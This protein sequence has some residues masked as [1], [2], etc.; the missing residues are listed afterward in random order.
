MPTPPSLPDSTRS[1]YRNGHGSPGKNGHS[2]PES[3]IPSQPERSNGLTSFLAPF[4]GA[5][6]AVFVLALVAV[7]IH[8]G[9]QWL[10]SSSG[11]TQNS[12]ASAAPKAAPVAKIADPLDTISTWRLGDQPATKL[13]GDGNADIAL[14]TRWF[15]LPKSGE[16]ENYFKAQGLQVTKVVPLHYED[17]KESRTITYQVFAQVPAQLLKLPKNSWAPADP[18]L[19]PFAHGVILNEGLPAGV[20]WNTENPVVEAEA[21]T[22]LN[23]ACK[24]RWDKNFNTVTT[25]RL[26][27]TDG[28]FTQ[29]QITSIQAQTDSTVS[30]LKAQVA[31][32]DTQ[33]Q[34]DVQ[35]RLV[36][37]A[38]NPPKPELMSHAWGGDGSG[39][40]TKSAERIGGGTLAG[41]A[42]GA[43]FGA[44]AGD[45][46]M[47]AGIGA[48]VGLLGG[49][50]YDGVSK[51]N[52]R[53]RYEAH[54]DAVNSERMDEW[55]SQ[56]KALDQQR[57]QIKQD[58]ETEKQQML[59]GLADQIAKANG[60][61]DELP[62]PADTTGT[63]TAVSDALPGQPITVGE[64]TPSHVFPVPPGADQPSGPITISNSDAAA[65]PMVPFTA[66]I[67]DS[68][69]PANQQA[70]GNVEVQYTNGQNAKWT[71]DGRSTYAR[72]SGDGEVGWVQYVGQDDKY[73]REKD[74]LNIYTRDGQM[75][76]FAG[77][78]IY[79]QNWSFVNHGAS[80]AIRSMNHH[81]PDYFI[82][83]DI[84][85][86]KTLD[87]I[88]TPKDA[89]DLPAWAVRV[90]PYTTK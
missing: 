35:G 17:D 22:Q 88:D 57:N 2:S 67:V 90:T 60:R 21:G 47:G 81:G 34:N 12:S 62:A 33:V 19:R 77:N 73:G 30:A 70:L 48:G 15:Y 32:I 26:P 86:G 50:I 11:T 25:D 29:E 36:Q 69:Y 65:Q 31:Q 79:I 16:V 40:P 9:L 37:V 82:K 64:V 74:V 59:T 46:G 42:G 5:F 41:A 85:T 61:M 87:E 55:H 10:H 45:A 54:V 83:Y 80:V 56:V 84:A 23:F 72:A 27:Y 51:S 49:L 24:V 7:G 89:D 68:P 44:A 63:P 71:K 28:V 13:D 1:G 75:K 38:P 18:E 43:A 3:R 53:R 52:D 58:G 39:E 78:A 4:L 20:F 14:W 8:L 6:A 76:T 66:Q